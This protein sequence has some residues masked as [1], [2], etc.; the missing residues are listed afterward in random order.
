M[1]AKP[2][3]RAVAVADA[4]REVL[5]IIREAQ[6][7]EA[8]QAIAESVEPE[9]LLQ[10]PQDGTVPKW[11]LDLVLALSRLYG[12]AYTDATVDTEPPPQA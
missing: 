11:R 10:L 9:A 7:F 8:T 6:A 4:Y 5:R 12:Q 3:R 2:P 1:E